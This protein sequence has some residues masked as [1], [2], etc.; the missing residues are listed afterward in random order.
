M[1]LVRLQIRRIRDDSASYNNA[2]ASG[3][4]KETADARRLL[5][6]DIH[7]LLITLHNVE[8][9]FS[10]LKRLAPHETEL[11]DLRNKYRQWLKR[12]A[13]FRTSIDLN[14]TRLSATVIDG[15]RLEGGQFL[16]NGQKLNVSSELEAEVEAFL[17]DLAAAWAKVSERQRTLRE[18]ISKRSVLAS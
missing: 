18:L 12:C 9:L 10:R 7:Y 6:A 3:K 14:E 13:E 2:V 4:E 11:T 8:Q 17:R 15:G 1:D 16:L 5:F